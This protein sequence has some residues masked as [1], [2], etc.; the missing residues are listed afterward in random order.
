MDSEVDALRMRT[1][2]EEAHAGGEN[3]EVPVG[4]CIYAEQGELLA[5]GFN[6]TITDCDPSAHAE[7]VCLRQAAA[8]VGNHR[9]GGCSLYVTLE[10]CPMCVGAILHARLAKVRFGATDPKTGACGGVVE[11]A[12][13]G[14]LNHQTD[15]AQGPLADECARLLRDF[16]Q[17]RR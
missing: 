5:S 16:F 9:L 8:K 11:L 6:R 7:I 15:F 14:Q 4:A 17:E 1:A 10:P 12:A 3:G 2:L 13:D